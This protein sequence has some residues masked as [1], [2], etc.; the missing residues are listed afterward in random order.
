MRLRRWVKVVL[1]ILVI[2]ISFFI[3]KQT[4]RLGTLSKTSDLYLGLCIASWIYLLIG[5]ALIYAA[6]WENKK[7]F[8][9]IPKS[10]K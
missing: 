10:C 7:D 8:K 1:T 2:H 6:I 3:W 5:Q 9:A 4:G